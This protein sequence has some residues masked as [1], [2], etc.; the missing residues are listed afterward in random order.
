MILWYETDYMTDSNN[1]IT[2]DMNAALSL[3]LQLHFWTA[4]EEWNHH[5][6]ETENDQQPWMSHASRGWGDTI[7]AS[8]WQ[9][10][11][12]K[13]GAH[14]GGRSSVGSEEGVGK[15]RLPTGATDSEQSQGVYMHPLHITN[16]CSKTSTW[17]IRFSWICTRNL[18]HPA[19]ATDK[20]DGAQIREEE[21]SLPEKWL[22]QNAYRLVGY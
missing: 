7:T 2:H 1:H 15:Q 19:D 21:I 17:K 3:S 14:S 16:S 10:G 18:P 9:Y 6:P 22:P 12:G 11:G 4:K 13:W 5:I 8:R 20:P